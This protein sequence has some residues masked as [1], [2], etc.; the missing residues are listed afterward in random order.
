M[1]FI[2][3]LISV[4]F[5]VAF[6]ILVFFVAWYIALPLLFLFFIFSAISYLRKRVTFFYKKAHTSHRSQ[7]LS[8]KKSG[9]IIDVDYT[10]V[11]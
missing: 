5:A 1:N 8:S 7:G 9:T 4:S 3:A 10:E 2:Q 6:F 11:P